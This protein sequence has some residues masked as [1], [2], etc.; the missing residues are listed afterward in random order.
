VAL[1]ALANL[2]II[3]PVGVIGRSDID[4]T[5]VALDGAVLAEA[6]SVLD[7]AAPPRRQSQDRAPTLPSD[8]AMPRPAMRTETPSE[9]TEP[10]ATPSEVPAGP[11]APRDRERAQ[12]L[13][14]KGNQELESGNISAARLFFEYAADAG[15][16]EAAMA[17]AGTFDASELAKL[18]VRGIKPDATEARRW[19]ER[20]RQ[21]GA[22]DAENRV[23]RL[24]AQ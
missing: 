10:H 6:K 18:N 15:L 5:L 8:A 17:L 24:G 1:A 22:V 23:R 19:Y 11:K 7:V 21:L 2:K 14:E 16:A 12:R 9:A 20:A 4:I 3:L 13:M